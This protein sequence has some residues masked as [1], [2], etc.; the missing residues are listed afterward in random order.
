MGLASEVWS[1]FK[2]F[3][4]PPNVTTNTTKLIIYVCL[5]FFFG[6]G[7]LI[8]GA[9]EGDR[10]ALWMGVC[11]LVLC[12]T[13]VPWIYAIVLMVMA[14]MQYMNQGQQ[15]GGVQTVEVVA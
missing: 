11:M 4:L 2:E 6:L 7:Q 13:I 15:K 3:H 5:Q 9:T 12:W 10:I 14:I 8:F 1:G